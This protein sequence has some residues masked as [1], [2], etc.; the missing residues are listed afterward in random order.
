MGKV[1][2]TDL[3][4]ELHVPDFDKVLDF[5]GKL[6]FKKVWEYPPKDQSGYLV[7][8][9]GE[10]VIAFFCGNNEVYNHPFFKRFPKNTVR[11][12]AVELAIYISDKPIDDYYQEVVNNVGEK[13]IVQPLIVKPWGSKD[14][15]M[16]DPFGFYL[17]FGEPDN[18]L[19]V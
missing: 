5:Y 15:R 12:Y 1:A 18:I 14:F 9:R 11:G 2:L 7:M 4:I 17:R 6:G 19:Q 10:S 3:I 8:K 13:Y 16:I